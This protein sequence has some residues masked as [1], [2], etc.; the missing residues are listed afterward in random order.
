MGSGDSRAGER[1]DERENGVFE[2]HDEFEEKT[3]GV[4]VKE[5]VLVLSTE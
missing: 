1:D 3:D 4:L 2:Q 5:Y